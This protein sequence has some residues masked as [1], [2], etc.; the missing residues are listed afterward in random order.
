MRPHGRGCTSCAGPWC[1]P[2]ASCSAASSNST[3]A[4]WA[5]AATASRAGHR[6][7][8]PITIAVERLAS[9]RLGRARLQLADMPSGV[10][11]VEFARDVIA[12]GTEIHTDGA[13]VF[14]RLADHGFT[15]HAH[16]GL[17]R[18]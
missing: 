8:A 16:P 14:T 4:S 13:L 2:N 7:K 9:G 15:H 3:R 1:D 10:D 6:E 11:Q 18:Q 17:P 5:A 12:P